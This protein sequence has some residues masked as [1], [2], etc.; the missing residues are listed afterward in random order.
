VGGVRRGALA[1]VTAATRRILQLSI[2]PLAEIR[3]PG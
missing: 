3:Q 1:P 2:S